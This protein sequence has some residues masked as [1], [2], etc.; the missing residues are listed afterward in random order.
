MRRRSGA[1]S[2]HD[3]FI[4]GTA[5]ADGGPATPFTPAPKAAGA[6]R[7]QRRSRDDGRCCRCR[8]GRAAGTREHGAPCRTLPPVHPRQSRQAPQRHRTGPRRPRGARPP[9]GKWRAGDYLPTGSHG[10]GR[11]LRQQRLAAGTAEAADQSHLGPDRLDQPAA[12]EGARPQRRRP[13]RAEVSRQHDAAAGLP[14]AR[15]SR[16]VGHG[17]PRLRAPHGRPRRHRRQGRRAIQRLPPAHVRRAVVRRR[18]RDLQDRL[19]LPARDDAG[20]PHDGRARARPRGDARAVQGRAAHHRGAG[21]EAAEHADPVSRPR[22]RR[23]Q[24]GRWRST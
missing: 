13:H 5:L 24:V 21:R 6:P 18:P 15:A 7:P 22:L 11:P 14:G 8:R 12:R 2:L 19:T 17:V 9:P 4:P 1:A 23:E 16:P 3:G 10:V 20:T